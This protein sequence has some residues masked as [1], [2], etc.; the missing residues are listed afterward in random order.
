ML[1]IYR[2]ARKFVASRVVLSSTELLS[3]LMENS[4]LGKSNMF[5]DSRANFPYKEDNQSSL[6]QSG[7]TDMGPCIW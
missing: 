2:L 4:S 5:Q 1:G 7:K 3:Q 6:V